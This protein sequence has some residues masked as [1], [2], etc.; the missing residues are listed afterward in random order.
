MLFT[1]WIAAGPFA[2]GGVIQL[3]ILTEQAG[4]F[5]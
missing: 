2:R 4:L 5:V 3:W 1:F